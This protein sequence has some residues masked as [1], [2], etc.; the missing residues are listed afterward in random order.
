MIQVV[1]APASIR[2]LMVD[3]HDLF[4]VGLASLL[5]ARQDLEVVAEAS[6]EKE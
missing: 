1:T 6:M 5:A 3:A 2:I 4:G